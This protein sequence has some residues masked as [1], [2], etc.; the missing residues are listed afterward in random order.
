MGTTNRGNVTQGGTGDS[1]LG[2][3]FAMSDQVEE[4][5]AGEEVLAEEAVSA[6][7]TADEVAARTP[8]P[9]A[10]SGFNR[11]AQLPYG[12]TTAAIGAAMGEFVNFL[13]LVNGMVGSRGIARLEALLMPANFSS[14]VGEFVLGAIPSH[15]KSLV[16]NRY[17]NGH[18]DLIPVGRYDDDA[19]Q[20]GTDGVEVK[21][22]RYLKGWQ[23]HNQEDTW[24]MVVVFDSNR[25]ADVAKNIAPK[26][27]R[28]LTVLGARLVKDDWDFA[29]RSA[30][31]RRTITASVKQSGYDKMVANWIYRDPEWWRLEEARLADRAKREANRLARRTEQEARRV[32]ALAR[33]AER[34]ARV[35]G[36][37]AAQECD[38]A[39]DATQRPLFFEREP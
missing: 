29:G 12:L 1:S 38:A 5:L 19:V 25:P 21:G 6:E 23:G 37:L 24:L 2:H 3:P 33:R 28:F 20:H 27:F 13:G 35:A 31:S 16:K 9:V 7:A 30:T 15:C 17:H 14:I 34:E 4:V 18:P 32:E 10:Q 22:S 36:R 11:D 26:S 39:I 8:F